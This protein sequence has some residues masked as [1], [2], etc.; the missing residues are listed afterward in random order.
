MAK[1]FWK[2]SDQYDYQEYPRS[3]GQYIHKISITVVSKKMLT[4]LNKHS[5]NKA[6]QSTAINGVLD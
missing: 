2:D 6:D 5:K 1:I 3:I 4:Q